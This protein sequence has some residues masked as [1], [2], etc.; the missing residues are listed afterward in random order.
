MFLQ[1]EE[2]ALQRKE[3]ELTRQELQRTAHA[4]EQSEVALRA[5][6]EAAAL[7]ARLSTTSALLEHYRRELKQLQSIAIPGSDP[8]RAIIQELQA[9]ESALLEIFSSLYGQIVTQGENE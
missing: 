6:A 1:R 8:R 7:S 9:R 3:L 2:L 4:Q 5:Q